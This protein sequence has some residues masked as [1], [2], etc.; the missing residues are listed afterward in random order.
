MKTTKIELIQVSSEMNESTY[1]AR[2]HVQRVCPEFQKRSSWVLSWCA[3][4]C[5]YSGATGS[6]CFLG[7]AHPVDGRPFEI[8]IW[9]S[10]QVFV[11]LCPGSGHLILTEHSLLFCLTGGTRLTSTGRWT[12]FLAPRF[13]LSACPS[14]PFC[15]YVAQDVVDVSNIFT[16]SGTVDLK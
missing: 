5:L 4:P 11:F 8:R 13:V 1:Q 14:F 15:K 2:L 9:T 7:L 10:H 6:T 16:S 12:S 3:R